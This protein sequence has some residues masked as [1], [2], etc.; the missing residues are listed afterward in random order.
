MEG[1]SAIIVHFY[2][3]KYDKI[4]TYELWHPLRDGYSLSP[5]QDTNRYLV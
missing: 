2:F 4:S 1:R 5:G 3:D